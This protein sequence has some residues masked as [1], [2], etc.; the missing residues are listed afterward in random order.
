MARGKTA[1]QEVEPEPART[2]EPV[3]VPAVEELV[4]ARTAPVGPVREARAPV[5]PVGQELAAAPARAVLVPAVPEEQ[6]A[7]PV[8]V[9]PLVEVAQAPVEPAEREAPLVEVVRDPVVKATVPATAKA[10]TPG[11]GTSSCWAGSPA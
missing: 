8:P 11:S 1:A 2:A 6:E 9:A 10:T 5:E 7:A 4:T 3:A